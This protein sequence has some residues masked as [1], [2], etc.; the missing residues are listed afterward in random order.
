MELKYLGREDAPIAPETWKLL[1]TIMVDAAKTILTGRRLLNIEGPYGLG[2]KGFPL[3]DCTVSECR[4]VSRFVPVHMISRNFVLGVRDLVAYEQTSL[5]FFP[6]QLKQAA[7]TVAQMEDSIIFEGTA[8]SPGLLSAEGVNAQKLASWNTV[9]KAAD[10]VIQAMITLDEAGYHGPYALALS[11]ARFNL[12]YR[13]YLQGIGTELEHIR[14]IVTE[15]V[16]KAPV[17]K[18]GGVLLATGKKYAS[19]PLGQDM[20]AGFVGPMGDSFEFSVSESLALLI[21]EPASICVLK[22]KA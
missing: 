9:G 11:P 18:S 8:E 12:L 21:R 10:D 6:A 15:G 4:L 19:L 5:P 2:L 16:F 22:E 7:I 14:T 20:A 17:M 13:R 3:E 1:D